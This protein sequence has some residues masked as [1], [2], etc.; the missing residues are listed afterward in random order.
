MIGFTA[1]NIAVVVFVLLIAP[2]LYWI[3]QRRH[4]QIPGHVDIRQGDSGKWHFYLYGKNG[5]SLAMS[6]GPGWDTKAEACFY[7]KHLWWK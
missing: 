7:A 5:K 4:A 3:L 2:S 1:I 6:T